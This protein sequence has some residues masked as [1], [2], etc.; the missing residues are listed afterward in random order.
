M[1]LFNDNKL[2]PHAFDEV[3]RRGTHDLSDVLF[4][5]AQ[6]QSALVESTHF[7]MALGTVQGGVTQKYLSRFGLTPEDW[8]KGLSSCAQ[9]SGSALPPAQLIRASLH[10]SAAA[11]LQ[12]VEEQMRR[13]SGC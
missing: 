2:D 6:T 1:N 3:V 5:A 10:P 8:Q 7:L 4:G 12:A 13:E 9:S 11:M